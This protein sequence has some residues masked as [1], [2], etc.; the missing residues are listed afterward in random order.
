MKCHGEQMNAEK[1]GRPL[2]LHALAGGILL[3][4]LLALVWVGRTYSIFEAQP[5]GEVSVVAREAPGKEDEIATG[6]EESLEDAP[7]G[8]E[9]EIATDLEESLEDAPNHQEPVKPLGA[10]ETGA[11]DSPDDEDSNPASSTR[12]ED[13]E[14]THLE[15]AEK[16]ITELED[17]LS[18]MEEDIDEL[19]QRQQTVEESVLGLKETSERL[20]EVEMMREEAASARAARAESLRTLE[21]MLRSAQGDLAKGSYAVDTSLREAVQHL[22]ELGDSA[23]FYGQVVEA[24]RLAAARQA[25]TIALSRLEERDLYETRVAVGLALRHVE[26]ARKLAK[27]ELAPR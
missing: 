20:A 27:T 1:T 6:L 21:T 8:Q 5:T 18:E 14:E 25:L 22:V 16:R 11:L 12:D 26:T 17:R 2:L 9:D 10:G 15:A 23:F 3:I 4:G 7:G 19:L 13:E 24:E